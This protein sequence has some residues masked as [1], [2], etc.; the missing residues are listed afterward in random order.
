MGQD[1]K[2]RVIK[3]DADFHGLRDRWNDLLAAS[4]SNNIFLS[5]E[6]VYTWWGIFK[7]ER[8]LNILAF[9]KEDELVG[10]APLLAREINY[11]GLLKYKR[12]EFLAS[13]E[14]EADEICSEYLNI[15]IKPGMEEQVIEEILNYLHNNNDWGEVVLKELVAGNTNTAILSARLSAGGWKYTIDHDDAA[16]YIQLPASWEALTGVLSGDFRYK[17][18]RDRKKLNEKGTV[19]ITTIN[20]PDDLAGAFNILVSLHQARW[21]KLGKQGCFNSNKFNEFHKKMIP[22]LLRKGQLR[23]LIM[24]INKKPVAAL[25]ELV[26]NKKVLYYQ[27]GFDIDYDPKLSVGNILRAYSIEKA[28]LEGFREYDF[29]KGADKRHCREWSSNERKIVKIRI[30]KKSF[31]EFIVFILLTV[32]KVLRVIRGLLKVKGKPC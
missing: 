25:Y 21:E 28:V 17:I 29:L 20:N 22:E 12:I 7:G 30:F 24:E 13:G 8:E 15:I 32:K 11:Y 2:V 5:W 23:L 16:P 14:D 3:D 26:Y 19:E 10:I 18:R 9:W 31:K 6:W 4:E 27:S 1:I